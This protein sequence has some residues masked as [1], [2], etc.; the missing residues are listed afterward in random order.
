MRT[1]TNLYYRAV[2]FLLRVTGDSI[3][4]DYYMAKRLEQS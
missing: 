1:I 4:A 3:T 2:E